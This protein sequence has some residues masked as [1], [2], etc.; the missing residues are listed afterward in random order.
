MTNKTIAATLV[1]ALLVAGCTTQA[2]NEEEYATWAETSMGQL[3]S[4]MD[5]IDEVDAW[6]SGD[7]SEQEAIEILGDIRSNVRSLHG[8][9]RN[10]EPPASMKDGHPHAVQALA[11]LIDM[12][13]ALV[14]CVDQEE[15]DHCDDAER[16][17]EQAYAHLMQ[18]S[19][20]AEEI[21]IG[22]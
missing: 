16:L 19:D 2:M 7:M 6:H 20:A 8:E 17:S 21:G 18:W 9:A 11:L 5:R 1:L 14:E 4:E 15:M 10:I 12:I 13:D 22:H 3:E